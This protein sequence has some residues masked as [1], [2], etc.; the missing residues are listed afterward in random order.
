MFFCC[1]VEAWLGSALRSR[2]GAL[3]IGSFWLWP[4][5]EILR[6]VWVSG[7]R[8]VV[9]RLPLGCIYCSRDAGVSRLY[10]LKT[11]RQLLSESIT[12]YSWHRNPIAENSPA[13]S[14]F[15]NIGSLLV[16]WKPIFI[17]EC[18]IVGYGAS[19]IEI[20]KCCF[21]CPLTKSYTE[22]RTLQGI[23]LSTQKC[24]RNATMEVGRF[25]RERK[26]QL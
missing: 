5:I 25:D 10:Q 11:R 14:S 15:L 8:A 12:T 17:T 4:P 18:Q 7:A 21:R 3:E 1:G 22:R 6:S 13:Y 2:R 20:G 26:D 19:D 9:A 24:A 16:I 23:G